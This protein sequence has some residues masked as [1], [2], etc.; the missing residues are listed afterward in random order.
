[1]PVVTWDSV[2]KGSGVTLS[3][4]NLTA[5]IPNL[6]NTV[7]ATISRN[8]GKWYWEIKC[9]SLS[10][11]MIGIVNSSAGVGT[12]YNSVNAMYYYYNGNKWNGTNGSYGASYTTG[13]IISVLLDLD[14]GTIEFWKNG[15][16]QGV[17]FT[18]VKSLGDVFPAVTSGSAS[19]GA[20]LTANFGASPFVY[21]I[22]KG[23]FSYDG[24][25]YGA[26]N[27]IL[28]LSSDG[29]YKS[30]KIG[31]PNTN[32]IPTMTSNTSPSGKANASSVYDVNYAWKAFDKVTTGNGWLS[33]G[34]TNQWLSYEFDSVKYIS[35][36]TIMATYNTSTVPKNWTF[37]GSNDGVTWTVLDTRTNVTDW[38]LNTKKEFIIDKNNVKPFKIYR[39]NISA[40]NGGANYIHIGEMEM[41]EDFVRIYSLGTNIPSE[42]DFINYGTDDLSK[43]DAKKIINYKAYIQ[44]QSTIL[45]SGKTF[46]QQIDLTRYKVNKISF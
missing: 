16:S 20:T 33:N 45:G 31:D 10:N 34:T 1:M 41:M 17:A 43:L 13:D 40:N 14:N 44:D 35:K 23:Y 29:E 27:K 32:L 4:G 24:N 7:R 46:T 30:A 12:T 38:I 37:E 26:I 42:Q 3:N 39:I 9:D 11:A 2:N 19:S 25:Q 6:N 8:S 22:P 18:N 28:I 36:Y 21:E 5:T 15:V